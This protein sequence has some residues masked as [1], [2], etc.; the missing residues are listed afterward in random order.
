ML[1]EVFRCRLDDSA[2][3]ILPIDV[4]VRISYALPTDTIDN[5]MASRS[6]EMQAR[7]PQ[8]REVWS[9]VQQVKTGK[10]AVYA[11][12]VEEVCRKYLVGIWRE[13]HC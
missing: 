6:P 8:I 1:I 3:F 9:R 12:L 4:I 10:M 11:V 13:F 7:I 2:E 5:L